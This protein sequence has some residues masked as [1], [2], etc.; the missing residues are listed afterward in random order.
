MFGLKRVLPPGQDHELHVVGIGPARS[1]ESIK[2]ILT[3]H[4]EDGSRRSVLMLGVAGA[5]DPLLKTGDLILASAYL[6]L[7]N[8]DRVS[9][10]VNL[11]SLSPDPDLSRL[12]TC[13]ATQAGL[14]VNTGP[15]VT[16]DTV[17]WDPEEKAQLHQDFAAT[18]VNMEDFAVATEALRFGVPFLSARVVLDTYEQPLPAYLGSLS[19]PASRSVLSV[20]AKP[21][22]IP[23]L[24]ALSAQMRRTQSVLARFALAFLTEFEA[25]ETAAVPAMS[26][27]Q[28]SHQ[29]VAASPRGG[30]SGAIQA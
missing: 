22:R 7:S 29:A 26:G 16:V 5:V 27:A 12:A 2:Q 13:A 4:S 14:S 11:E 15:A 19:G 28:P 9:G 20:A 6:R 8:P 24:V 18:S 23:E 3:S 17:V 1:G 30:F 10:V 25:S 21:W